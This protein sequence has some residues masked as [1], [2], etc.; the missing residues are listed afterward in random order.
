MLSTAAD[1]MYFTTFNTDHLKI[2]FL[3]DVLDEKS[4]LTNI[5]GNISHNLH[6]RF[7]TETKIWWINIH[8]RTMYLW[9]LR[10]ITKCINDINLFTI[11]K[12]KCQFK[13]FR[14]YIFKK[15]MPIIQAEQVITDFNFSSLF[16]KLFK[17]ILCEFTRMTLFFKDTILFELNATTY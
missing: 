8:R 2:L 5:L 10:N 17:R 15:S 16:Q 3:N 12:K 6:K 1:F 13:A 4:W 7:S 9:L 14:S 11:L